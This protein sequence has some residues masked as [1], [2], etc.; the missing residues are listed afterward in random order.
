[1]STGKKKRGNLR[2][3]EIGKTKDNRR[4]RLLVVQPKVREPALCP[5]YIKKKNRIL[6]F[7]KK[8]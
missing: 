8:N 7:K 1:M 3:E 2:G 6:I 4:S 5:F